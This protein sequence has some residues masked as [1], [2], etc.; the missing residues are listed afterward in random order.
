MGRGRDDQRLDAILHLIQQHPDKKPAWLARQL[1]YDNKIVQRALDQ[2]E[3][4]GDLL[5]EDDRGRL[6][7]FGQRGRG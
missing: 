1:G 5:Q 4:R 2:L 7:W 6:R 3:E